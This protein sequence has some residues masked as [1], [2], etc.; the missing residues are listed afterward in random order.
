MSRLRWLAIPSVLAV[1]LWMAPLAFAHAHP[2]TTSP[3]NGAHLDSA[4]SQVV[5]NFDDDL[6]PTGTTIS[7]TGPAGQAVQT[8]SLIF[9]V[10]SPKVAA[11]AVRPAGPGTYSVTWHATA[12]DDKGQTDGTF[13]FTVG[14]GPTS[15]TAQTSATL[16]AAG[17]GGMA[18]LEARRER[19]G[20]LALVLGAAVAGLVLLLGRRALPGSGIARP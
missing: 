20:G 2:V 3:A 14:E 19:A 16:P 11:I 10:A 5:I 9:K 17:G 13:S 6:D 1:S 8:G 15:A 7:V 18:L 12:D 4:P